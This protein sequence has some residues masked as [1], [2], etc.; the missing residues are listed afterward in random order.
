MPKTS[1]FLDI[2]YFKS[3]ICVLEI[4]AT[5]DAVCEI[6]FVKDYQKVAVKNEILN[7][8][9]AELDAYFN[10]TLQNFRTPVRLY[11]TL[12]M[13]KIYAQLLKIPYATTITY[14][15]LAQNA[16]FK[17]AFRAAGTANAK[18]KIPIIIPC[19]RVVSVCG[20]GGYSGFGG[21]KTKQFL[22]NLEKSFLNQNS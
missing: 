1:E 2:C 5:K 6:N 10:G 9:L 12:F 8:C 21:V 3:P 16:G 17:N 14:K 19:H 18:N 4:L 15:E 7:L 13:Q 11:G 20:L 22:L